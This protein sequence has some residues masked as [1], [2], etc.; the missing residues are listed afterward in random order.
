MMDVDSGSRNQIIFEIQRIAKKLNSETVSKAD[1]SKESNISLNQIYKYF[2]GWMEAVSE[3]GLIPNTKRGVRKSHDELFHTLYEVCVK[4]NKIPTT[5]EFE[6][7]TSNAVKPYRKNFGSW[8]GTLSNFK[9][10][11]QENYSDSKFINMIDDRNP[12]RAIAQTSNNNVNSG[13]VWEGK[14][15]V[16]YGAP[17][18]YKG[19]RHEPINEQGV[20]FLFGKINEELGIIVEAVKT[21]FPDCV[22]KRL[23]DGNKNLWEPVSIEFE[24]KSKNFLTHGH[25]ASKCDVIVCWIHDWQDCPLEVIELK[26]IIA[27][28]RFQNNK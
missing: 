11:L 27:S 3:A 17:L 10:W 18:D 7:N 28:E 22:G 23:I 9:V 25:D 19:L 5:I 2:S 12:E 21:G 15:G 16:V 24:Y 1:F 6:R 8:Q 13:M 4:L 14:K 26:S 20:V